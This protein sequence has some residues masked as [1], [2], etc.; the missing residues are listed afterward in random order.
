MNVT[1]P[2]NQTAAETLCCNSECK[3]RAQRGAKAGFGIASLSIDAV[4]GATQCHSDNILQGS[5][6]SWVSQRDKCLQ[7]PPGTAAPDLGHAHCLACPSGQLAS[8]DGDSCQPCPD[9]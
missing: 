9:G 3:V 4:C 6:I 2:A 8:S 5:L 7:C 1:T